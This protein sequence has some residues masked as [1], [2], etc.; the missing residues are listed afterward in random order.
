MRF[1]SSS[2]ILVLVTFLAS[3]NPTLEEAKEYAA[4]TE[5]KG[6][7]FLT[8]LSKI[9]GKGYLVN[10]RSSNIYWNGTGW[11]IDSHHYVSIGAEARS[12]EE[13]KRSSRRAIASF[14]ECMYVAGVTE[15][16]QFIK[17]TLTFSDI[18][19]ILNPLLLGIYHIDRKTLDELENWQEKPS[20]FDRH[21][22]SQYVESHM[23]TQHEDWSQ[24]I[25][26]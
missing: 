12:V 26:E 18:G 7:P 9:C 11:I 20:F 25:L 19:D 4:G 23:K 8:E 24:I 15:N 22:V 3:C 6:L 2:L 13:A 16:I 17:A 14:M 5:D 10:H 1:F 21:R